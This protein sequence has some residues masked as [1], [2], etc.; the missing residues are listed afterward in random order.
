MKRP[1]YSAGEI[2]RIRALLEECGA[3]AA[4]VRAAEESS[5]KALANLATLPE[6]KYRLLLEALADELLKRNV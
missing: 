2:L 5:E 3:R 1:V 6:S 4:V